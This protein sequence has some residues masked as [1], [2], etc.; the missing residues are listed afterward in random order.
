MANVKSR[1]NFSRSKKKNLHNVKYR[2]LDFY[3]FRA[4]DQKA[5]AFIAQEVEM[6]ARSQLT[7]NAIRTIT[8]ND[9]LDDANK[10]K[11]IRELLES[12]TVEQIHVSMQ[13]HVPCTHKK[14]HSHPKIPQNVTKTQL[15][16]EKH[17]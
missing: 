3:G 14:K 15:F 13:I 2:I 17:E 6:M 4:F 5:H 16:G 7:L 12:R 8:E 9:K 1:F 11:S 10:V